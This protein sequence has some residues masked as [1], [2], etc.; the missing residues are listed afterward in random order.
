MDFFH[1]AAITNSTLNS[2]LFIPLKTYS[3]WDALSVNSLDIAQDANGYTAS[4]LFDTGCQV[5]GVQNCT[6]ACRDPGSAFSTLDTLHNCMMYPVIADQYSKGN[7]SREIE[8]LAYSLGIE[9]E[10]WPSS[11][12]L[13]ITKT[14]GTCLD[15]YCSTLPGCSKAAYQDNQSYYGYNDYNYYHDY[16]YY[17]TFLNPTGP[18]YFNP[19]PNPDNDAGMAFDLCA[20]FTVS[21]NQDTGGIGVRNLEH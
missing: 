18:F 14:I 20:Y 2:T 15:A 16:N 9:K 8:Q 4:Y 17:S 7:L 1:V 5:D 12:S 10:Q 21:A 19:D 6:A 11:I 13:N 3:L